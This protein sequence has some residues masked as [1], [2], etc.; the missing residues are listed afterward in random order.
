MIVNL[1][2]QGVFSNTLVDLGAFISIFTKETW[3]TIGLT[4]IRPTPIF[5]E[6][7]YHSTIQ[8]KGILEDVSICVDSLECLADF[9]VLH[10]KFYLAFHPLNLGQC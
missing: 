1:R 9:L 8:P 7:A 4:N 2:K 10:M 3:E 6:L 5:I